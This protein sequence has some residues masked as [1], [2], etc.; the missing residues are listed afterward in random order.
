MHAKPP[1]HDLYTFIH[2][3]LRAWMSHVLVRV[4]QTDWHDRDD[5]VQVLEEVRTL[6]AV[7]RRHIEHEDR[8]VHAAMEARCPGSSR[9]TGND[10]QGQALAFDQLMQRSVEAEYGVGNAR[11]KAWARLYRQLAV[12]V[13]ENLLHMEEEETKNNAVLWERYSDDELAEIH[14]ALIAS[15]PADEM[16]QSLEW[17]LPHL[18]PPERASLLTGLR[19]SAPTERYQ[20]VLD[21]LRPRLSSKDW[22]KLATALGAKLWGPVSHVAAA[23]TG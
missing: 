2:K 3:A 10:H 20:A 7:C 22:G 8:F 16:M 5:A 15:I 21:M 1:R 18:A 9:H 19:D 13:A 11:P 14:H 12:F 4:G 6:L 17:I 23:V